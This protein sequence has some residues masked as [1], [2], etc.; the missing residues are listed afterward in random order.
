MAEGSGTTGIIVAAL[1]TATGGVAA[2]WIQNNRTDDKAA[3]A[4]AATEP[5]TEAPRPAPAPATEPAQPAETG[6]PG[7]SNDGRNRTLNIVNDGERPIW[8]IK[9]TRKGV[10]N[11]GRHDWLGTA[12]IPPGQSTSVNFDDGSSACLF[13]MRF[14][15]ASGEPANRMGVDVCK[16]SELRIA[17]Q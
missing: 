8:R 10:Q 2:A 17:D 3:T 14:E 13:D 16:V 9:A 7:T 5:A 11:F 4:A 1:I 6:G 15:F 12:A